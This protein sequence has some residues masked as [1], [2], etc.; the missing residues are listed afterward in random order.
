MANIFIVINPG[1]STGKSAVSREFLAP[2]L[3]DYYSNVVHVQFGCD[4]SEAYNDSVWKIQPFGNLGKCRTED[5]QNLML[6]KLF[7]TNENSAEGN[8]CDVAVIEVGSG[9]IFKDFINEDFFYIAELFCPDEVKLIIPVNDFRGFEYC[10][11]KVNSV[12]SALNTILPKTLEN[13]KIMFVYISVCNDM[14]PSLTNDKELIIKN[15]KKSKFGIYCGEIPYIKGL[16]RGLWLN[17]NW[18]EILM[19]QQYYLADI[20]MAAME[21]TSDKNR[22]AKQFINQYSSIGFNYED[23][24]K[25][26]DSADLLIL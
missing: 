15:L 22:A 17:R 16:N 3:G 10:M 4:E 14:P 26:N 12:T 1:G 24:G 11:E 8:S 21:K 23:V 7:E 25:I 18:R 9:S 2:R 20:L 13:I 6:N 5:I 19:N